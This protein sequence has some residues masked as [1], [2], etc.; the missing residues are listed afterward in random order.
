MTTVLKVALVTIALS[1]FECFLRAV[2]VAPC[3]PFGS[4]ETRQGNLN[5]T[6]EPKHEAYLWRDTIS[7]SS[8]KTRRATDG[9]NCNYAISS[10]S[11]KIITTR[12]HLLTYQ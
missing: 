3:I 11:K 12:I 4:R 9:R 7:A 2:P 8:R 1:V 5:V 6:K 10:G